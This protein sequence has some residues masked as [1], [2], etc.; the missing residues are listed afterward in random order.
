MFTAIF[1][2]PTLIDSQASLRFLFKSDAVYLHSGARVVFDGE[3]I[4]G[5]EVTLSGDCRFYGPTRIDNG[6][7]LENVSFGRDN[8]V[9][10]YSLLSD[11]A[12]GDR[13]MFGPFCFIRDNCRIADDCILGAHVETAR[14]NF[15]TR[16]KVSHRAFVGDAE[17]AQDTIIGAGVVFCNFDGSGRQNTRIG[18]GVTIGSGSLLIPP[19]VIGENSI[20]AAG[21]TVTKN[22]IAGTTLIQKR[23]AHVATK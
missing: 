21:S 2:R 9:R 20:I 14:S 19:L 17:I 13:N 6:S 10:A 18:P 7:I 3:T 11:V 1:E 22:V 16:V 15:G 5:S 12:A 4:L 23:E 8:I